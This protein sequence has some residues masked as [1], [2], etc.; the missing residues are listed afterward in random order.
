VG[1]VEDTIAE[2]IDDDIVISA[3]L[4]LFCFL[5]WEEHT[6]FS[7]GF[8]TFFCIYLDISYT[9]TEIY[10]YTG[11]CFFLVFFSPICRQPKKSLSRDL[12]WTKMRRPWPLLKLSRLQP[13]PENILILKNMVARAARQL[14]LKFWPSSSAARVVKWWGCCF[15]SR[16]KWLVT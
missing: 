12:I 4:R 13:D 9:H 14:Q 5:N 7:F 1:I 8:L 2:N 3:L 15:C 11:A 6:I 10:H 16:C